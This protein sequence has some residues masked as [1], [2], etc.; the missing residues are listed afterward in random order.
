MPGKRKQTQFLK[1][2]QKQIIS[3]L[4]KFCIE[5]D[6]EALHK[7]RVELKKRKAYRYFL[8]A[9][10]GKKY[11]E[12]IKPTKS[13]FKKAGTIR[14]AFLNI[15]LFKN[16]KIRNK[17]L[18]DTQI[19]TVNS[20][21][22]DFCH[23]QFEFI[24]AVKRSTKFFLNKLKKVSKSKTRTFFIHEIEEMQV[25]LDSN[26]VAEEWHEFRKRI[27][28]VLYNYRLAGKKT[29]NKLDLNLQYLDEL[30]EKIGQWHDKVVAREIINPRL[31][32]GKLLI[33]K[34]NSE[35]DEILNQVK[36]MAKDFKQKALPVIIFDSADKAL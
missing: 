12:A 3:S 34:L 22:N 31:K 19:Q 25:N 2:N 20:E 29:K 21:T 36:E 16:L 32:S 23:N 6:P 33:K 35:S 30:Q 10:H 18:H 8:E 13:L 24:F 27:K 9:T 7:M 28:N 1:K 11:K 15:D 26:L 4:R 17:R 5:K 14:T